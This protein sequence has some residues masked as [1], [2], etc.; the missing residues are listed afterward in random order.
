[1]SKEN[2]IKNLMEKLQLSYDEALELWNCDNGIETN[3]EQNTLDEKAKK[4]KINH[5]ATD[6]TKRKKKPK[7]KNKTLKETKN[8]KTKR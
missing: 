5:E 2:E 7:A 4:T 1:M 3:E 6:K 8:P